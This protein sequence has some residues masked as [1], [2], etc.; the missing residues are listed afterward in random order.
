[1]AVPQ[2]WIGVPVTIADHLRTVVDQD[3]AAIL[4][5]SRNEITTLNA[6]G[7]FVWERLERGY[8]A[9]G[10]IDEL[11]SVWHAERATVADG[12]YRFL[13]KLNA[14]HLISL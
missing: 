2:L 12:V 14:K 8:A 3:G 5:I 1:M 6:S 9:D 11:A 13:Q 10:I 4:D 7:A